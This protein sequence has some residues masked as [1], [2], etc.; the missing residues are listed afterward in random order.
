MTYQYLPPNQI[1]GLGNCDNIIYDH[2]ETEGVPQHIHPRK[3]LK[4]W[5]EI[6]SC[7]YYWPRE[8]NHTMWSKVSQ[9]SH[10]F[11]SGLL[12]SHRVINKLHQKAPFLLLD[13]VSIP[14][15]ASPMETKGGAQ[16]WWPLRWRHRWSQRV[17]CGWTVMPLEGD[18]FR[19]DSDI[20]RNK[21]VFGEVGRL[22]ILRS[23]PF[24]F[25]VG[26]RFSRFLG[27]DPFPL[28]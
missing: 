22:V 4:Q 1:W 18:G 8:L 7:P 25:S 10:C 5:L 6:S 2:L 17:S 13:A 14:C 15:P 19:N 26:A 23:S 27:T 28:N 3:S 12:M 21:C 20:I 11:P 9:P 24:S 16:V